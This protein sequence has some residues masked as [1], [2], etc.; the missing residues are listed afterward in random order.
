MHTLYEDAK[1]CLWTEMDPT[2]VTNLNATVAIATKSLN[3]KDYVY[4]PASGEVLN[5]I[6]IKKGF[7]DKIN[8]GC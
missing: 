2:F 7:T 1:V 6:A 8:I 5:E 4:H 3:R